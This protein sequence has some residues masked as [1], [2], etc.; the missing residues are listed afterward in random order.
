M[1]KAWRAPQQERSVQSL[2]RL[3]DAAE[4]LMKRHD[5]ESISVGAIA[6]EAGTSVGNFYGRFAS[7]EALLDALHHRYEHDRTKTWRAF[8]DS[9]ALSDMT[10]ENRITALI[11]MA[12]KNYR[13]RAGVF[14]TLV[15]RQW[16]DPRQLSARNRVLLTGLYD[17]ACALLLKNRKE[18]KHPN[19][20]QAVRVG[21]AAI[22]AACR[23]NIV[24]RPKS[25]PSALTLTD[26]ELAGE[27]S[28]ML[29]A[30]LRVA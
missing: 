3:L 17:D 26:E 25:F 21:V 28:R 13:A 14:R 22:A 11:R 23:E 19:P 29:N 16:R 5:F 1:M 12:I 18:I 9:P 15:I 7:K 6:K 27:L 20:E 10:L 4:R 2:A 8:L 24:M 30:Y